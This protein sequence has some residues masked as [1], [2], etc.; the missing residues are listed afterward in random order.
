MKT[1]I[2]TCVHFWD[3]EQT[4]HVEAKGV[5]RLCGEERMFPNQK[6]FYTNTRESIHDRWVAMKGSGKLRTAIGSPD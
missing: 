3:C 4:E 1:A 2:K 5:C 6:P